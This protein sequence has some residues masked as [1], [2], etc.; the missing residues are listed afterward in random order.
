[1]EKCKKLLK[2]KCCGEFITSFDDG[3]KCPTCGE[4]VSATVERA[5]IDEIEVAFKEEFG[6]A[7]FRDLVDWKIMH[8]HG[9]D[10]RVN[11]GFA[12]RT[13]EHGPTIWKDE[14]PFI[15]REGTARLLAKSMQEE[16]PPRPLGMAGWLVPGQVLPALNKEGA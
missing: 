5:T 1:M 16:I 8:G 13:D 2:N 9:Y 10:K 15:R 14:L 3:Y 7:V 6:N 4:P 11:I 12:F